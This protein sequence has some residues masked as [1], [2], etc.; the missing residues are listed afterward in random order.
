MRPKEIGWSQSS[1]LL[2]QL[3]RKL[4]GKNGNVSPEIGWRTEDKLIY[5]KVEEVPCT[6]CGSNTEVLT[7]TTPS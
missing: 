6:P 3:Q 5:N 4:A 7:T 1:N 2:H